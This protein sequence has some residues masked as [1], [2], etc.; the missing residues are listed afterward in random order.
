MICPVQPAGWSPSRR[1]GE[2]EEAFHE[3]HGQRIG[4]LACRVQPP[5]GGI[6]GPVLDRD[7]RRVTHDDVVAA[8]FE[9]L[10]Q[11]RE[12]L[13]GVSEPADLRVGIEA[14]VRQ[15]QLV[16]AMQQRIPGGQVQGERRCPFERGQ[17]A[18]FEGG[19]DEAEPGDRHRERVEVHAV[20]RVE[21]PLHPGLHVQPRRPFRP[22]FVEP[23]ERAEQEVARAAGRVDEP[24][25]LQR[26]LVQGR[27]QGLVEDELLDEHRGLQQGVGL[28]R[29][30]GQVLVEVTEEP[31]GQVRV[32]EVADQVPVVRLGAPELDQPFRGLARW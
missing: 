18:G 32:G 16:H 19:D 6:E 9:D 12:I 8:G 1:L 30:L 13:G 3:R 14:L 28:L 5:I 4:P 2:L 20:D 21:R 23:G 10:L 17:A 29:V 15:L 7:I 26:A 22:A 27:L 11:R 24:D 31:G 25:P